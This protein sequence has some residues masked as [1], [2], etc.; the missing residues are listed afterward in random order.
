MFYCL[1]FLKYFIRYVKMNAFTDNENLAVYVEIN[2]NE[3]Y[4]TIYRKNMI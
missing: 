3:K 4:I 1:V 2:F